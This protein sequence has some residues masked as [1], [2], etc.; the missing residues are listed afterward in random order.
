LRYPC[1]RP[2]T[3]ILK[4]FSSPRAKLTPTRHLPAIEAA[5][6]MVRSSGFIGAKFGLPYAGGAF[7]F[8]FWRYLLLSVVLLA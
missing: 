4:F 8:L 5:F 6:L 7:T 3:G 1:P 2:A